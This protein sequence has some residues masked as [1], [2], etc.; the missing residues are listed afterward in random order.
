MRGRAAKWKMRQ[1]E[2]GRGVV[3]EREWGGRESWTS[4][5]NQE[6]GLEGKNGCDCASNVVGE[7]EG[8]MGMW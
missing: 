2:E 1:E 3:G 7:E 6:K 5:R 4:V 8:V